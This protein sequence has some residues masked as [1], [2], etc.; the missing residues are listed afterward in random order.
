MRLDARWREVA[1]LDEIAAHP[2]GGLGERVGARHHAEPSVVLASAV[3][4][5]GAREE[6]HDDRERGE[7]KGAQP[8]PAGEPSSENENDSH[9][10]PGSVRR[11]MGRVKRVGGR[12]LG[13][14]LAPHPRGSHRADRPCA[15]TPS[16]PPR[17]APRRRSGSPEGARSRTYRGGRARPRGRRPRARDRHAPRCSAPARARP[18]GHGPA[19]PLPRRE[20]SALDPRGERVAQ[21]RRERGARR[22]VESEL[23]AAIMRRC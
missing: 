6:R 19:E 16:P 13:G 23:H 21:L 17:V 8:P 3:R 14:R 2:R 9:I 22:R 1:D 15:R 18:R 4:A 20:A 11:A 5:A 7:P 12:G 10:V